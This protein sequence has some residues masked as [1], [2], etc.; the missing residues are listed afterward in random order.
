MKL[1]FGVGVNDAEYPTQRK[2]DGWICPYYKTWK[3]MLGRCH[4][5]SEK[6]RPYYENVEVCS[7]WLN[8]SEFKHWMEKEKW[9]NLQLDKDI[10][11]EGNLI[12]SPETCCFVPRNINMLLTDRKAARGEYPLGVSFNK[13][14]GMFAAYV[15]DF[16]QKH[17]G[18]FNSPEQAHNAW[19]LAKADIIEKRVRSWSLE[20]SFNSKAGEA[21][22]VRSVKLRELSGYNE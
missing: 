16:K 20:P 6:Y 1:V 21:L 17:L 3:S 4:Y 19:R 22:L 14:R 13:K 11:V 5:D 15:V 8:F 18:Y 2:V 9:E 10:L 7:S 12:Y